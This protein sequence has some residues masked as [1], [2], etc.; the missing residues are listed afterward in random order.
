[1]LGLNTVSGFHLLIKQF[2]TSAFQLSV[3]SSLVT[4]PHH[5]RMPAA[6]GAVAQRY[7]WVM[8]WIGKF[9]VV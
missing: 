1:M 7:G 6:F 8:I 9:D 2:F 3:L 5:M 4:Q